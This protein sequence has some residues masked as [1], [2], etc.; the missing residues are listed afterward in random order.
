VS[1]ASVAPVTRSSVSSSANVAPEAKR[2]GG[3]GGGGMY[4]CTIYGRWGREGRE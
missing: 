3:G 4:G 2:R 1:G